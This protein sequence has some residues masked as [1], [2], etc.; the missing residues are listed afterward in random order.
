MHRL[1][2]FFFLMVFGMGLSCSKTDKNN[3]ET[4]SV[5]GKLTFVAMYDLAISDPSGLTQSLD[6]NTLWTVSDNPG[7]SVFRMTKTGE[8]LDTLSY[9][10]EDVESIATRR[11][12][13]TLFIVEERRREVL[14][15]DKT[16]QVIRA[17]IL[18][19]EQNAL[20]S[21]LEGI[22]INE[23]KNEVYVL[24][25][26]NPRLYITLNLDDLS[27]KSIRPIN[28]EGDF[29]MTDVS[30]IDYVEETDEVWILSDESK[31]IVVADTDLNPRMVYKTG[32]EKGE[33]IA[34]DYSARLVYLVDDSESKLYVFEF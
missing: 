8:I 12:T 18:E 27:I 14:E 33:G 5:I 30:G 1:A 32:L 2:V 21:G 7:L 11:S 19:I 25:E 24:N 4:E 23:S 6:V 31:K 34:V 10:G 29:E 28:F 3:K 26:K 15:I 22:T 9:I 20:N 13:E 16:G 17:T